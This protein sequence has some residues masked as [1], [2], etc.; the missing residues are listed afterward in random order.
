MICK[1]CT[2]EFSEHSFCLHLRSHDTS[3]KE[4]YDKFLKKENE[5]VCYCQNN[6][7]FHSLNKGYNDYC[8]AK[9]RANSPAVRNKTK[10][11]TLKRFGVDNVF[12]SKETQI[13]IKQTLLKKYN[14]EHPLQSKEIKEKFRKTSLSNFGT[15]NPLQSKEIKEKIKQINI[16]N[17]GVDNPFK[18]SEIQNKCRQTMMDA[19]GVSFALQSKTFQEKFKDTLKRNHG[20]IVPYQSSEIKEK[21]KIT[22]LDNYGVENPAQSKEIQDKIKR[23]CVEHFGVEHSMQSAEVQQKSKNTNLKKLGVEYPFQSEVIKEKSRLTCKQRFGVSHPRQSKEIQ[24]KYKQTCLKK[25]GVDHFSKTEKGK[26]LCREN[27]IDLI[28]KQKLN[29]EPLSPRIGTSERECLNEFQLISKYSIIRNQKII[30]YFPDGHIPELKLFI[31][32]DEKQ[33]FLDTEYKVYI[34]KDIECTLQL[35]ALGYIVFRVSKKDWLSNKEKVIQEFQIL[36]EEIQCQ[37]LRNK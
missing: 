6:T 37:L 2:K 34:P 17:L 16:K 21:G 19:Y 24:Y 1:I 31:Q 20:V 33:H 4:Y 30:G 12:R 15:E 8:S 27:Y 3:L 28:E 5:G 13:K 9:C 18:L 26:Q 35:A 7:K 22:C 11:T 32:F 10:E 29:N 14:V 36:T 23:S 25:Y